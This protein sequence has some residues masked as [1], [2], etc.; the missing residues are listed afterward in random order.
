MARDLGRVLLEFRA[1]QRAVG[2]AK[3]PVDVRQGDADALGAG[4]QAEQAHAWGKLGGKFR[5]VEEL[6]RSRLWSGLALNPRE[7]MMSLDT[8]TVRRIAKL[9]RIRVDDAEIRCCRPS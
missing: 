6:H 7:C 2:R 3:L 1:Q 8:A 9:A 4:V 5:E